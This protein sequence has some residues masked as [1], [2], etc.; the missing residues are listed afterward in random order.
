MRI[1]ICLNAKVRMCPEDH[2]NLLKRRIACTFTDTI[3][4]HLNLTCTIQHACH[5]VGCCHTKVIVAVCGENTGTCCESINMLIEIFDLFTVFIWSTET[6]SVRNV[7]DSSSS[8]G[9]CIYD[10]GKILVVG[11]S[12]ILGI[13][14]DILDISLR[15]FYRC[16]RT[17]DYLLG[18]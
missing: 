13:E 14:L 11:S 3:D 7:A 18:V 8:L 16:N 4:R 2:C 9:H 12:S 6:C 17:L 5:G 15:I 1:D 10:T